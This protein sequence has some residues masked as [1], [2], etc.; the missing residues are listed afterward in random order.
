MY[1][2]FEAAGLIVGTEEWMKLQEQKHLQVMDLEDGRGAGRE[3]DIGQAVH[4]G[5]FL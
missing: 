3:E 5:R 1:A 2:Q 4:I